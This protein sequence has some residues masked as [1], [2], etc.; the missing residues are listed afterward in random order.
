MAR[1]EIPLTREPLA[2]FLTD[3]KGLQGWGD[4]VLPQG[5][6]GAERGA[7]V[8]LAREGSRT[9]ADYERDEAGQCGEVPSGTRHPVILQTLSLQPRA[10]EA[11][12]FWGT[13]G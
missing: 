3:D 2:G 1:H 13:M 9:V 8:E 6:G 11:N 5:L 10:R 12:G 7:R 4:T